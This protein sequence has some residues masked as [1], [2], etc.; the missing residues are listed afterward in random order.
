MKQFCRP[1][2]YV[3]GILFIAMVYLAISVDKTEESQQFMNSLSIPLQMEYQQRIDERR[4][5]YFRGFAFGLLLSGLI[6]I[7]NTQISQNPIGRVSTM[8]LTG[9]VTLTTAYFYYI[10]SKKQKLMIYMLES[11]EQKQR[12]LRIYKKMQFN[13]HIGLGL[14]IAAIVAFSSSVC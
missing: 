10:L 12:W 6:L 5:L 2:C 11:D 7:Y 13:Y 8:C 9:F 14:G 1:T 3:A 4:G